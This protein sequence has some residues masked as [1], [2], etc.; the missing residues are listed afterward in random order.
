MSAHALPVLHARRDCVGAL[1]ASIKNMSSLPFVQSG[2]ELREM[3]ECQSF[4]YGTITKT[5]SLK[6]FLSLSVILFLATACNAA[7]T[8][9]TDVYLY[10]K[11]Y[12]RNLFTLWMGRGWRHSHWLLPLPVGYGMTQLGWEF[13]FL[14]FSAFC[15]FFEYFP[16]SCGLL[17]DYIKHILGTILHC[18]VPSI[19]N[20]ILIIPFDPWKL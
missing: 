5:T 19:D 15:T 4:G 10:N 16:V 7:L 1:R 13:F 11:S 6:L 14:V 18:S 20:T 12:T 8:I 17:Y 3:N 9:K 2:N